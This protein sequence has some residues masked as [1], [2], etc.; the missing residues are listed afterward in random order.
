M[1]VYRFVQKPGDI[2]WV[3]AGTVHWVQALGWCNNI[4]WNVGP[5]TV[6]QY[7]LGIQRYEWNK[8][9]NY[10]SI[11]PMIH[12][13]WNIA[14]NVKISD[15]EVFISMKFVFNCLFVIFLNIFFYRSVLMRSL[16]YCKMVLNLVKHLGHEIKWHGRNQNEPAH[17]C[18]NCDVSLNFFQYSDL[19]EYNFIIFLG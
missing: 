2:V 7:E 19:F 9:E 6:L 10:K 13:T 16:K 5:F 14:R 15:K 8:H 4:A 1:P 3:G 17:Y 11:V 18:I 12:L